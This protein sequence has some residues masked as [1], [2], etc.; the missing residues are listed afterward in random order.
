MSNHDPLEGLGR[1]IDG[2]VAPEARFAA[3]LKAQL[4][5][6]LD[7]SDRSWKEVEE[8]MERVIHMSPAVSMPRPGDLRVQ[9]RL[10]LLRLAAVLCLALGLAYGV[11]TGWFSGDPGTPSTIPAVS[12]QDE[13]GTPDVEMEATAYAGAGFLWQVTLP[14][15]ESVDFGGMAV[16]DGTVY[17]LLATSS[18]V[19]VEAVDSQTGT[20]R[21][22]QNADLS[23]WSVTADEKG[24]YYFVSS[25]SEARAGYV[26]ALDAESGTV[27]WRAELS[28]PPRW[29]N[30]VDGVLYVSDE[31][32]R[33]LAIET[34]AG[35]TIWRSDADQRV[36]TASQRI[37]LYETPLV[38]SESVVTITTDGTVV[39]LDRSTGMPNWRVE[40]FDPAGTMVSQADDGVIVSSAS[41][42]RGMEG[43][44]LAS[45]E[46]DEVSNAVVKRI[47]R[48]SSDGSVTWEA[49]IA[50]S[51]LPSAVSDGVVAVN[52]VP[53]DLVNG[54]PA[55]AYREDDVSQHLTGIDLAS[56]E[57]LWT[58]PP[59]DAVY[60][61]LSSSQ[62]RP[63]AG[64]VVIG[65]D[66]LTLL[67]TEGELR[68]VS[69]GGEPLL[70][71]QMVWIDGVVIAHGIDGRL[72][73]IAVE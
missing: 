36:A 49:T 15:G 52:G 71:N 47:V 63:D 12:L 19:G 34:A 22:K 10:T 44:P 18:F 51:L 7:P 61:F 58:T 1:L 57:V 32:D 50:G 53:A 69:H 8:Q 25:S 3:D 24:V 73:G 6:G 67:S 17:R 38:L 55:E 64:F 9:Q 37:V 60:T 40:G 56:G 72:L 2:P 23:N 68:Q 21:W 62:A 14:D 35:A 27:R 28:S 4:L 70:A 31:V 29:F 43:T 26:T 48:I 59:G 30:A 5:S 13:T 42:W 45:P 41:W 20:V 39:S 33:T 11:S 46:T 54:Q 65:T 16:H 66:G